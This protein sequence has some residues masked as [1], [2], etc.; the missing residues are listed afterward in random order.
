MV[1]LI[2]DYISKNLVYINVVRGGTWAYLAHY[3]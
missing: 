3:K 1:A 2:P